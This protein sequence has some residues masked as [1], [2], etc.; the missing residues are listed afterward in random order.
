MKLRAL[1]VA[2]LASCGLA[3]AVLPASVAAAVDDPTSVASS[4]PSTGA[5][6]GLLPTQVLPTDPATP[7]SGLLDDPGTPVSPVSPAA[8][9]PADT[10]VY[11]PSE[12]CGGASGELKL[13]QS[14][15][16][17]GQSVVFSACG[18]VPGAT[19]TIAINGV[20]SSTVMA[21]A[22]GDIV[23]EAVLSVVGKS[24]ITATGEGVQK[25][26]IFGEP[27]TDPGINIGLA[28][29]VG[30]LP[31]VTRVTSAVVDVLNPNGTDMNGTIIPIPIP[32]PIDLNGDD[33]DNNKDDCINKDGKDGNKDGDKDTLAALDDKNNVDKDDKD[34]ID[35]DNKDGKDGN[36]GLGCG[37]V[38][39]VGVGV[40][41]VGV[42]GVGGVGGATPAGGAL[43]FTGVETGAMASIA[44]ALLGGGLV[45]R[46]A[47]RRRRN[48]LGAHTEG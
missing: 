22:N 16:T 28:A 26:G 24:T 27:E 29:P 33:K 39:A 2:L 1:G 18:Y 13:N 23:G 38:G 34:N 10:G 47:A 21:D 9:L 42:G 15:V 17:V 37:G 5:D 19:V 30:P 36:D 35:K 20:F 31:E 25:V 4:A 41:G 44:L 46:V 11:P 3:L 48:T 12:S 14:V 45:L 6:T 8:L 7:Q 40:L 43:P 32:I